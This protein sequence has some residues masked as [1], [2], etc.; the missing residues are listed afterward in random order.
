MHS[1][2][3]PADRPQIVTWFESLSIFV[4]VA[5]VIFGSGWDSLIFLPLVLWISRGRSSIARWIFTA[6]YAL[7]CIL[8]AY[9]VATKIIGLGAIKPAAWVLTVAAIVQ[10][11]LLWSADTSRWLSAKK[12]GAAEVGA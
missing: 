11:W 6:L 9:G 8:G 12:E 10:L 5:E 3:G 2:L 1:L 7:G 4:V